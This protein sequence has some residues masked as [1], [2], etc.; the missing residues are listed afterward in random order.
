MDDIFEVSKTNVEAFLKSTP[1]AVR[2]FLDW[3]TA[4]ANCGL[5]RFCTLEDVVRTYQLDEQKFL[6]EAKKIIA[7]HLKA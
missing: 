5:A 1:R 2:F 6:E 3:Q 4:C 7:P